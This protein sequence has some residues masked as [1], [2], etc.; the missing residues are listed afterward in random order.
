MLRWTFRVLA[1]A[2]MVLGMGSALT[3]AGRPNI[4]FILADDLGY[5][6]PGCYNPASKIPTPNIDRLAAEGMRFT[7]S[8]SPTAVCTPTRYALLTGRFCWRTRLKR[9]VLWTY[10][11][12]L[13]EPG[14][15]TLA[16]MLKQQGYA[17]ACLGKWHLGMKWA[18]RDGKTSPPDAVVIDDAAID[19]AGPI[20]AGPLTAGF[21]YYFGT[22]VPNFPPYCFLENDH[23]FGP[24]PDRPKP[25]SMY[26]HPGRMQEGWKLE[27]IL[28]TL[29]EK[30]A[31]YIRRQAAEHPGEPF[32]LYSALT[33]PHT[34]IAPSASFQGRSR[35][36]RYGDFV[37]QVDAHLGA[38]LDA[39]E[40]TGTAKETIVVFTS[41][42]GSPGRNGE[43]Y[44]GPTGSCFRDSGH[45]P[46]G[47][48]RGIKAD[49][50]EG[51]HRVPFIV[52]W[53]GR[54]P[55]GRVSDELICHADFFATVA[56]ILAC[57]LPRDAAEDSFNMLPVLLDQPHQGPVRSSLIHHSGNGMFAIRSGP[58]KLIRGQG[59]G[60]FTRVKVPPGSPPGQLYNLA[61]DPGERKN[62][63]AQRPEVVQRLSKLLEQQIAAGRT[64][65]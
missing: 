53:P 48:W 42:N 54:V 7:D 40:E 58:W 55:A 29:T 17:T 52:R 65:P 37:A 45:N 10:A 20:T 14:R 64:R 57:P 19:L 16:Q 60:G 9:G 23:V 8:H 32:F 30:A 11:M 27:N 25:K 61:D 33:A 43:N 49:I 13:I 31:G 28:P 24:V 44:E 36:T 63:Y 47:P 34:P 1:A 56:A 59:S 15:L 39:L 38:V 22:A 4:V 51:G 46:S 26:G 35:A 6:D 62:L 21:D 50:Q 2:A 3:A 12:P 5:G 41:D 18:R